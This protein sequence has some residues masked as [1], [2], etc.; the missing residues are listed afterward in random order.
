MERKEAP[1]DLP[2]AWRERAQ[3]L[4]DWGLDAQAARVW[5]LAATELEQALRSTSDET[6]SLVEAARLS[7]YSPDHLGSLV[8][9]GK[10][11]NS[12]RKNAPRIKRSDLPIKN[13]EHAIRPKPTR[14]Q[15][16]QP[17]DKRIALELR[18]SE[19]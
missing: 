5:E 10:L 14:T 16:T 12:G 17:E 13:T 3:Q 18:K 11:H 8:R 6:L 2:A 1:G 19:E 15:R 4:R 7:G 9:E